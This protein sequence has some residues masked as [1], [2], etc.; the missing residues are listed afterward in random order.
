MAAIAS[1]ISIPKDGVNTL[2]NQRHKY[3]PLTI[4]DHFDSEDHYRSG[5]CHQQFFS[6]LHSP[7]RSYW[8][9]YVLILVFCA[10][11]FSDQMHMLQDI[12][13]VYAI[14]YKH[15]NG[16]NMYTS[17]MV[18]QHTTCFTSNV[19]YLIECTKCK[20]NVVTSIYL[21]CSRRRPLCKRRA[22]KPRKLL[23]TLTFSRFYLRNFKCPR[24]L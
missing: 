23:W 15:Y 17:T 2:Y 5:H 9:N 24:S 16:R 14:N 7:E 18:L 1:V 21:S 13:E 19:I 6:K 3:H 10:T 12:W 4:Q 22:N 8:T 11:T 20:L